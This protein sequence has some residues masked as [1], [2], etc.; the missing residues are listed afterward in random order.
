MTRVLVI[1]KIA[2][3]ALQRNTLRSV[4][5]A[6]GIIIGVAAVIATV[7]IGNG[8]RAAVESQI[9]SLGQNIILVS[10]GS[11]SSGGMRG[12][13]GSASTLAIEDAHAIR[14]EL[15][16]VKAVSP[17]MM[18]GRTLSAGAENWPTRIMGESEDYF[19]IRDWSLRDGSYFTG[20]E[21]QNSAKVVVLGAT[22]ANALFPDGDA[23]GKVVRVRST[24]LVVLGVLAPKGAN[25]AGQDQDDLVVIPVTAMKFITGYNHLMAINVQAAAPDLIPSIKEEITALLRQRHRIGEGREDD[26]TVRTQDEIAAAATQT[27]RTMTWLLGSVAGVSLVVG[28]IGIMNIMLVSVTERTREIGTRIA[29]GARGRDILLQFLVEA[30]VLS[31][32]GG[33]LGIALGVGASQVLARAANMPTEVS[34]AAITTAVAFSAAVGVF[35]GFYPARKASELDPIEALRFE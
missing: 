23:V 7:A 2:V 1:L 9:A 19:T 21:V 29:V 17:E 24:P 27:A 35:F 34:T 15:Y 8:A 33:V 32:L 26:F 5:T 25:M 6:L 10:P 3:R 30:V 16:G 18:R 20:V 28:G 12:G 11:S 4:L 31:L 22:V 13:F 14:N